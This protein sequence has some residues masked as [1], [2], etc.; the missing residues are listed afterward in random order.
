M[1]AVVALAIRTSP[2]NVFRIFANEPQ[3]TAN[4]T[5][6]TEDQTAGT[7]IGAAAT[8]WRMEQLHF[9]ECVFVAEGT[10]FR[11]EWTLGSF[12]VCFSAEI[13]PG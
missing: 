13:N 4:Y 9:D 2:D 7:Q 10:S 5:E 6:K 12:S 8:L 3:N 1:N 11:W